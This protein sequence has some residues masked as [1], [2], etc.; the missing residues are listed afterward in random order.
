[1]RDKCAIGYG[2]IHS[3]NILWIDQLPFAY[4]GCARFF[5]LLL[6]LVGQGDIRA[7]CMFAP[8]RPLRLT[9]ADEEN[10]GRHDRSVAAFY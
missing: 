10:T 3:A 5:D 2:I 8:L 4:K 9:M 6:A 7:A 1:M